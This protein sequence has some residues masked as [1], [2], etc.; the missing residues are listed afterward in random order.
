MKCSIRRSRSFLLAKIIFISL[1]EMMQ[2]VKHINHY[3]QK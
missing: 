2:I 1:S 3:K